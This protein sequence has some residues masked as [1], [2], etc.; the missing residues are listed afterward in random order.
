MPI[1]TEDEP[2][3]IDDDS[4]SRVREQTTIVVLLTLTMI[5]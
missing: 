4:P 1:T 5:V 3:D 2:D